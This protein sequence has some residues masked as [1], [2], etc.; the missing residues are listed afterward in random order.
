M[1]LAARAAAAGVARPGRG[2]RRPRAAADSCRPSSSPVRR[3]RSSR[4][5]GEAVEGRA[6]LL[7]AGD[8]AESFRNVSAV[9]IRERLK[10][11]LQ[12]SAVLTY[13]ATLP[14][15]KVGQDRGAVHE[16]ALRS[17]R[18]GRRRRDSV[19]PRPRDPLRRADARGARARPG[20]DGAG[21]LPG[22]L[23][24]QPAAR[25]HEG[26]LRR[27]HAGAH[28][29]PGVRDELARGSSLR[30]DRQ[31]DRP[32]SAVHAGDRDRPRRRAVDP[33]GGHLDEPR[34]ASARL[35]GAAR[36]PRLDDGSLVRVL[37]ALPLG[38]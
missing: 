19:V 11:L 2:R 10:V 26:R 37:G 7:Q 18:N 9:A 21:V 29:E 25:L 35:R 34:G 32:G 14:V 12:M 27:P 4:A 8:C 20:A 24:A 1:A 13:G 31:R 17:D 36:A 16:A 22:R 5:L 23:D 15:V 33:R 3:G 28:V 6:F 38:R 30:G